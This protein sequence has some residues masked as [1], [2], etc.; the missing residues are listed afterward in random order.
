MIGP[1]VNSTAG[2][3]HIFQVLTF[4][5]KCLD[6]WPHQPASSQMARQQL[7]CFFITNNLLVYLNWLFIHSVVLFSRYLLMGIIKYYAHSIYSANPR[8]LEKHLTLCKDKTY[9]T[10]FNKRNCKCKLWWRMWNSENRKIISS[11]EKGHYIEAKR[12]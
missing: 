6:I 9:K 1:E 3:W 7:C 12:N 2:N 10:D 4:L 11:M 5:F 8:E